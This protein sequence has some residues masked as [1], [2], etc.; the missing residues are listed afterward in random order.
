MLLIYLE[1]IFVYD[2]EQ[3]LKLSDF[4]NNPCSFYLIEFLSFSNF[5]GELELVS[6]FCLM[7]LLS[8]L[9]PPCHLYIF[10]LRIR[11]HSTVVSFL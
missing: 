2:I 3:A 6:E 5:H 7:L 1:S 8:V 10:I 4:L 11:Q 9:A